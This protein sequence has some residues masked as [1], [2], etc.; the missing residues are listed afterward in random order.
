[1]DFGY[2]TV[3]FLPVLSGSFASSLTAIDNWTV[4]WFSG[5]SGKIAG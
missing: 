3:L 4:F 1:M 5:I 2:R